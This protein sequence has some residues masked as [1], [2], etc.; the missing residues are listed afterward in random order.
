MS[1]AVSTSGDLGD[2]CYVL[3]I[4]AS[5][6]DAP[7]TLLLEAS[8]ATK[9][10]GQEGVQRLFD[11]LA[12]LANAQSYIKE[13]RI[14]NAG[15]HV[16]WKS[17]NFRSHHYTM[18]QTLMQAHLNNLVQD[19]GIGH[20][21]TGNEPWITAKPSKESK[22]R[23]VINRTGRYRNQFFRWNEVVKKYRHQLLFIGLP[24]EWQEFI[25]HHGY[26]EFRPTSNMLEVAQLI[27][28]AEMFIGNQSCC[29]AVAEGLKQRMIQETSTIFPDC[30]WS[31]DNAQHVYDGTCILWGVNGDEDTEVSSYDPQQEMERMS[32]ELT[33]PGEW[34][35]PNCEK[36]MS[37]D[38]ISE[39]VKR[40]PEFAGKTAAD[41]KKAVL[42]HTIQREPMWQRPV[43]ESFFS[44]D[45]AIQNSKQEPAAPSKYHQLTGFQG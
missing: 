1:L 44:V 22:G 23:V 37:Y 7:H 9:A 19:K 38:Q 3:A 29:N 5:L 40:L 35:Y 12:P 45:M 30:V 8:E 36:S 41:I 11:T 32:V 26:V 27:A 21:I 10:K 15:E 42:S 33:P 13:C 14:I 24:H 20:G 16:D 18:G 17:A 4:L 28:G 43:I 25:G 34:Q 31:R 39:R 2:A 6:P